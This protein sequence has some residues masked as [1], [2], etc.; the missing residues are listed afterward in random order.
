MTKLAAGIFQS[1]LVFGRF[2]LS[3]LFVWKILIDESNLQNFSYHA[4]VKKM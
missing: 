3:K 1:F 2:Q 4:L